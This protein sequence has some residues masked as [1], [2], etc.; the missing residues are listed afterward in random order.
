MNFI[1]EAEKNTP[2]AGFLASALAEYLVA[3]LVRER[4]DS[5]PHAPSPLDQSI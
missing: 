1:E 3:A 4:D 2:E 5:L